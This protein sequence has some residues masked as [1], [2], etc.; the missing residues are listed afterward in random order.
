MNQLLLFEEDL[1]SENA[2]LIKGRR[3]L[4]MKEILKNGEGDFLKVGLRNGK[5]GIAEVL[6]M[7]DDYAEISF[8]LND[9]PPAS[10]D[11]TLV[12]ALCRPKSMKRAL[13]YA[14]SMGVK[15]IH[16]I[17][18]YR[19]DKSYFLSPVI[20]DEGIFETSLLALEQCRDTVFPE[21][22]IHKLFKPFAEDMLPLISEEKNKILCHPYSALPFPKSVSGK[23]V[24]IIGPD[25]GF[26][27][28]EID[29]LQGIGFDCYSM[30]E[31][32]LRT[33]NAVA[34]VLSKFS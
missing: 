11:V 12:L 30:G 20:S 29:L 5:S 26:I 21:V 22:K 15:E 4:H 9:D 16:I 28:Y 19:V 34:A 2:A 32:I 1:V 23:S 33:E 31:R 7:S 27:Q 13:Y 14:V 10:L 18:S 8:C 3:F 6:S 24:I 17:R 25:G